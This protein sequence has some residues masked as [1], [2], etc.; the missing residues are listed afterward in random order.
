MVKKQREYVK[1]LS[2]HGTDT[3]DDGQVANLK[4][5]YKQI[6]KGKD[7]PKW[8]STGETVGEKDDWVFKNHKKIV[9]IIERKEKPLA[10]DSKKKYYITLAKALRIL[11]YPKE[12]EHYSKISSQ[13]AKE[14]VNRKM[15]QRMTPKEQEKSLTFQEF[16]SRAND[17]IDA[18]PDNKKSVIL[19]VEAALYSMFAPL[20]LDYGQV[21][22]WKSSRD[23]PNDKKNYIAKRGAVWVLYLRDYAK[24]KK[25][26][27]DKVHTFP[28]G[29]SQVIDDSIALFPRKYLLSKADDGNTPLTA[30]RSNAPLANDLKKIWGFSVDQI[31]STYATHFWALWAS[32]RRVSGQPSY[33]QKTTELAGL[34]LHDRKTAELYYNKYPEDSPEP[35]EDEQ[36]DDDWDNDAQAEIPSTPRAFTSTGV[37]TTAAT[38]L[39][40]TGSRNEI[41]TQT[42][43]LRATRVINDEPRVCGDQP[44]SVQLWNKRYKRPDTPEAKQAEK[45]AKAKWR[46][47]NADKEL[48]SKLLK[49]LNSG[50]TRRPQMASIQRWKLV[51]NADKSWRSEFV[52]AN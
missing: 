28:E 43:H 44:F 12:F 14:T 19:G 34:M 39:P 4:S 26:Y 10:H 18:M 30:G 27:G 8:S 49:N 6:F 22:M 13:M 9:K 51:E 3:L 1:S 33:L 41:A 2:T 25:I 40:G 21:K 48:L 38:L 46:R 20:R 42:R 15:A 11:R 23:P 16:T 36:P 45:D 47:K 37:Q 7:A 50:Q 5:F 29:L 52:F 24:T 31:R 35:E 32:E 17:F